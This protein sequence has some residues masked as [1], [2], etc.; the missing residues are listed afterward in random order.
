MAEAAG[1]SKL[2]EELERIVPRPN[3]DSEN[4]PTRTK[5]RRAKVSRG[6]KMD[7]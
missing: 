7:R 1:W 6:G 2:R 3:S 5:S 4:S